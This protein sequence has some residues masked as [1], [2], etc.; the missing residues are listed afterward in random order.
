M[1]CASYEE[2][3]LLSKHGKYVCL[4]SG[5]CCCSVAVVVAMTYDYFFSCG[6]LLHRPSPVSVRGL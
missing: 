2:V 3:T 4:E 5:C 6:W 1:V